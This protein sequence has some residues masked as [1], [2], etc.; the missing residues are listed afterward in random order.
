MAR[1]KD[2]IFLTLLQF[3]KENET[4]KIEELRRPVRR[5]DSYIEKKC[6]AD[7]RSSHGLS[8]I[9]GFW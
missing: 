8:L 4:P 1:E 9:G 7:N 3:Q 6:G 5:S 2:L